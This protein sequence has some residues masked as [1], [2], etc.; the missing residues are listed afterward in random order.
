MLQ[1]QKV[2][3]LTMISVL[4]IIFSCI[5]FTANSQTTTT[6]NIS[7]PTLAA[8]FYY[9][10]GVDINSVIFPIQGSVNTTLISNA[11]WSIGTNQITATYN[12]ETGPTAAYMEFGPF[13]QINYSSA[14]TNN[15]YIELNYAFSG[16]FRLKIF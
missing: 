1:T 2:S 13:N 5:L 10:N 8:A 14:K 4:V 11:A 7:E 6:T 16:Y 15:N 9:T 3:K 12:S